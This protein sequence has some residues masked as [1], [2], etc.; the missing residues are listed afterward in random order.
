MRSDV[1]KTVQKRILDVKLKVP[2]RRDREACGGVFK[3]RR[4]YPSYFITKISYIISKTNI[5][6]NNS[7]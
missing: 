4:K 2:Q 5:S 7:S 6:S 1:G 3:K